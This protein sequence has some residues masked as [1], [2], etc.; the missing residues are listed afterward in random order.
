MTDRQRSSRWPGFLIVIGP[1][2][3]VAATGVGAGDLATA[4]FT[5]SQLGTA[6]LWAVLV[7]GFALVGLLSAFFIQM[8]WLKGRPM[9]A[10]PPIAFFSLVGF[11][12]APVF[13]G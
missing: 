5:G 3:L 1:G 13:F 10:L 2:L 9:P 11:L 4:S 8:L 12:L 7:G 6:V